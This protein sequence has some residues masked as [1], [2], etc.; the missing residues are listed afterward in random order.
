[1]DLGLPS[2]LKWATC[3]VG[4]TSPEDYGE[5]FAWGEISPKTEYVVENSVTIEL[6]MNDISGNAQYDAAV[7]NWGGSWRM[8]TIGEMQEL[9]DNCEFESTQYN[10][11]D[12][13]KVIGPNGN[14]IFLP[15]AGFCRST[16]VEYES[17]GCY[18]SSTPRENAY[19]DYHDSF[20]L[21]C[22]DGFAAANWYIS[23][24]YGL[25]VRPVSE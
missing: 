20:Y 6:Q 11:V 16:Y 7:A 9:D 13:I 3:N 22:G 4:A 19:V 24:G 18:W 1:M 25:N 5:Y 12:G 17:H 2:G 14:A 10:G 15:S 21:C 8:P 23:R